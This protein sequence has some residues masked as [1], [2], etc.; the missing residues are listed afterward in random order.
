MVT[1]LSGPQCKHRPESNVG[2]AKV[3]PTS[4][5]QYRRWTNVGQTYIAVWVLF[6][7]CLPQESVVVCNYNYDVDNCGSRREQADGRD[8]TWDLVRRHRQRRS[9]DRHDEDDDYFNTVFEFDADYRGQ[10]GVLYSGL[11]LGLRPANE[12]R[13]YL[14]TTSLIGWAQT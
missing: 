3:G 13:R 8:V 6:R 1:I 7:M 12:R 10:V 9:A 4:E 2:W 14:V 11:I 5:R